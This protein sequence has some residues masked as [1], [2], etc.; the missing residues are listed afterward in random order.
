MRQIVQSLSDGKTSLIEVPSPSVRRGGLL[1]ET[2]RSL[3]SAGTERMLVDFGQA[4][5]LDKARQQ[6][7]KVRQVLDKMRARTA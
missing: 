1:I 2:T 6:P 3:I 5:W 7:D 4:G